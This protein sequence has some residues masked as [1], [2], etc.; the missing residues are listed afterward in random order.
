MIFDLMNR[1]FILFF[2][3]NLYLT[4]NILSQVS[5]SDNAIS[6]GIDVSYGASTF[7]GGVSFVDFDDDGWDDISFASQDGDDLY[8]F[9]N[10]NGTFTQ[11]N[12]P[13]IQNTQKTK[14]ITWIDYDNDG[15]KD[16]S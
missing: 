4:N 5:F 11:V 7:G 15:D 8:F 9:K 12:F 10:N 13:A 14:Q 2:I 6:L 1:T 3:L 16:Y